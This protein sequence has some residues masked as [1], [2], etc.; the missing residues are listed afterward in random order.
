MSRLKCNYCGNTKDF[1]RNA[2]IRYYFSDV[3]EME[4]DDCVTE[5]ISWD[6]EITCEKCYDNNIEKIEI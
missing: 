1:F 6:H 3:D 2:T 5:F 4:E